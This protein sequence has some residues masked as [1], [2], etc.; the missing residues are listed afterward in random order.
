MMPRKVIDFSTPKASPLKK[1]MK[2]PKRPNWDFDSPLKRV[3][4]DLFGVRRS[5]LN[6]EK[7]SL[8]IVRTLNVNNYKLMGCKKRLKT[9]DVVVCNTDRLYTKRQQEK[10]SKKPAAYTEVSASQMRWFKNLAK[11]FAIKKAANAEAISRAQKQ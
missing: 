7:S 2:T 6:T 11:Q 4:K 9:S 1:I 5:K 8:S 3:T 10:G